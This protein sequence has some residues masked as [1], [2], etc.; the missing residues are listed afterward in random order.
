MLRT[1]EILST[2]QMLHAEHLDLRTVT[3]SLNVDDCAAPNMDHM[4]RKLREKIVSRASRLVEICNRIGGKYGIP[5]TNKRLAI[6]PAS[7]LLAGHGHAAAVQLGRT[8]D[9]AVSACGVDFVGG[10]TAL[11]HKGITAA[12]AVVMESL[13]ELV[14]VS[15][16]FWE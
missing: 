15:E 10:F 8:L 7:H 11:V 1:D 13:P 5:V 4:C 3:L 2:I 16:W 9:E 14:L 12:D 6:S